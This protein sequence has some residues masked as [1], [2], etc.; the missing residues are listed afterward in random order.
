MIKLHEFLL[1]F[2][3][4]GKSP[5]APGTV[6]SFASVILWFFVAKWFFDQEISLTN[7]NIFWG[8]FLTLSFIYGCIASPIYTKQF[9]ESDH[10][11]IVLDEVV[12]QILALQITF[13][14]IRENYFSQ[15][16]LIIIHSLIC[17]ALFRFFDIK[18]PSIIGLADQNFKNGFGVMFDDLLSGIAAA[19]VG[20]ILIISFKTFS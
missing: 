11:T 15:P 1:T 13:S 17:F 6:G 20:V 8:I 10:Q 16:F 7:Q 18:K 12:G 19:L 14:L 2:F 3:Y 5:K 9:D 4:C